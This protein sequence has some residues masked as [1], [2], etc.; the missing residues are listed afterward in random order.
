MLNHFP[1]CVDGELDFQPDVIDN[2]DHVVE[3]TLKHLPISTL[4]RICRVYRAWTQMKV[5]F[6]P[7]PGKTDYSDPKAFRLITLSETCCQTKNFI[8]TSMFRIGIDPKITAC[9]T[10]KYHLYHACP[11]FEQ[12]RHQIPSFDEPSLLANNIVMLGHSLNFT[13]NQEW[14][15]GMDGDNAEEE[16]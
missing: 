5:I 15:V 4:N 14:M 10:T 13:R 1:Y 8:T 9:A 3:D 2:D 16:L 6:L 11:A 12:F 7:K